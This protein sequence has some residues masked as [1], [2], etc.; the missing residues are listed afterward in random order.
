M[1]IE[2]PEPTI[3]AHVPATLV[4]HFPYIFGTTTKQEPHLDWAPAIH[5]EG[6]DIFYAPHAYPGGSPA[7]VVRRATPPT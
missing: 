3:P 7:W 4:K 1:Q 2:L 6:P 5:A